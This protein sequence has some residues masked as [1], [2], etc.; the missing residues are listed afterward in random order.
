MQDLPKLKQI[1]LA[2]NNIKSVD[3]EFMCAKKRLFSIDISRNQIDFPS[4][5]ELSKFI[6]H[7]KSM[8]SLRILNVDHNPFFDKFQRTKVLNETPTK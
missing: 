3:L 4:G 5:N 6:G 1:N 7:M 8:E 2:G